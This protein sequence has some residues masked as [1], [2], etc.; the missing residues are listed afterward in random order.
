MSKQAKIF[1]TSYA[2]LMTSLFFIMLVLFVLTI[3]MMKKKQ[4]ATEIQKKRIEEI[5]NS[6][7]AL[8]KEYFIYDSK[9]KRYSL[10]KN[11]NFRAAEDEIRG[12]DI[13]YLVNVGR[14]IKTLIRNL[15][16]KFSNQDIKYV[17]IIE[18]MSSNDNYP[19]NFQLSY[20][21]ALS[22]QKLWQLYNIMPDSSVCEVQISGSGTGGIGRFPPREEIKNQRILIQ[23][24]PKIGKLEN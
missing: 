4:E 2:D 22:V 5:Q 17:V 9:Y 20:R 21:R 3:A 7:N 13:N 19:D 14:S 11:I 24:V 18:G 15:K 12:A 6:V 8:P 10:V 23:I 16:I 1:W